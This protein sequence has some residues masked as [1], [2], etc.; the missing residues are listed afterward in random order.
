MTEYHHFTHPQS[1]RDYGFRDGRP[2]DQPGSPSGLLLSWDAIDDVAAAVVERR[3]PMYVVAGEYVRDGIRYPHLLIGAAYM[4]WAG[5]ERTGIHWR[6][7]A[8]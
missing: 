5:Y 2:I 7:A 3:P 8:A 4:K 1:V 6:R